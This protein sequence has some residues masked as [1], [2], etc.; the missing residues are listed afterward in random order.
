[1]NRA[2]RVVNV[3]L[4]TWLFISAFVWPH[5]PAQFTNTWTMGA[6]CTVIA[7]LALSTPAVRYANTLL[8]AWVFLSA[9]VLP[10]QHR[11]TVWNNALVA[12]AIFAISLV[13]ATPSR[14]LRLVSSTP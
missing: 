7:G 10:A 2:A 1:M 3:T 13:P 4:A 9:F 6:L 5:S 8:A 12:V 11:G 14:R